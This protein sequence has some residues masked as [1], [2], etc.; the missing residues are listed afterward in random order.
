M[1]VSRESSALDSLVERH[2][3]GAAEKRRL[4]A[5]VD[6]LSEAEHAPTAIRDRT[7]IVRHHIADS[8]SGLAIVELAEAQSIVDVGSGAGFPGLALAAAK[9]RVRVDL[10]EASARKARQAE[11]LAARAGI[12]NARVLAVRAEEWAAGEGRCGYAACASRAVGTLTTVCEYGAPLIEMNGTLVIWKGRRNLDE[13]RAARSACGVLGLEPVGV[14]EVGS[15]AGSRNRHLYVY[16]K[17]RVTPA[18]FPRRPG[19]AKKRPLA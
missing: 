4:L 11:R 9:P 16:R 10:L 6:G 18:R 17:V 2:D 8:L 12:G 1:D 15:L 3:L 14:L 5:L 13:E 7:A 19:V